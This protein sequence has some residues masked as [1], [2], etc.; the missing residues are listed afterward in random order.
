M[1]R[2]PRCSAG[3]GH[4]AA[5]GRPRGHT[6]LL[7]E[8]NKKGATGTWGDEGQPLDCEKFCQVAFFFLYYTQGLFAKQPLA[9]E[10]LKANIFIPSLDRADNRNPKAERPL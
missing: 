5:Q 1:K 4:C 3:S 10:V 2:L 8:I 9:G 7:L 6:W